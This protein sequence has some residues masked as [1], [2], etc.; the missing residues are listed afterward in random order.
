LI[1]RRGGVRKTKNKGVS[2]NQG[3]FLHCQSPLGIDIRNFG[4]K[5]KAGGEKRPGGEVIPKKAKKKKR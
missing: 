1:C 4:K 2:A 3:C 5:E